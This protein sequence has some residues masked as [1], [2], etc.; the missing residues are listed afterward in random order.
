V[1]TGS[2]WQTRIDEAGQV[3]GVIWAK[4]QNGMLTG[5]QWEFI[6]VSVGKQFHRIKEFSP[7]EISAIRAGD[8]V[9]VP[10][11][12]GKEFVAALTKLGAQVFQEEAHAEVVV[13]VSSSDLREHALAYLKATPPPDGLTAEELMKAFEEIRGH[14]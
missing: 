2:P 12:T 10:A 14:A 5:T 7:S 13:R 3:K 11:G 8:E 6:P 9:R 1:Y 4:P